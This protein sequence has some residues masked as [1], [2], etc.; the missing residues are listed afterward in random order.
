MKC[1]Y[2]HCNKE[3]ERLSPK[4]NN[5][6]YCSKECR[7]SHYLE[8][9]KTK[10]IRD[11]NNH[12]RYNKY[13]KGKIQCKECGGWYKAVGTHVRQIHNMTAREYKKK[14]G[15]DTLKGLLTTELKERKHHHVFEN[16]TVKNLEAGKAWRFKKGD[17]RA[18]RY[19]RSQQTI[20]RLKKQIIYATQAKTNKR[21]HRELNN[22]SNRK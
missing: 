19:Q 10:A 9:G 20:T 6:K 17:K 5:K 3:I 13:A 8:T 1:Q 4:A 15:L 16:G 14:H 11:K 21:N 12:N 7:E 22:H 2:I 18:G